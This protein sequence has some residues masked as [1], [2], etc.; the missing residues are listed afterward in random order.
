MLVFIL[1]SSVDGCTQIAILFHHFCSSFFCFCYRATLYVSAVFAVAR[2]PSVRQSICPIVTL[3]HCIHTAE[4]VVKLLSRPSS[5]II[6]VFDPQRWC[7]IPR[8]PLQWD[9]RIQGGGKIVAIFDWNRRYLGNGTRYTLGC[10]GTLIGSH[11]CRID[12]CRFRWPWVT[13]N[14]GLKV[15]DT[16][17]SNS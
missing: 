15:T 3:V 9:R 4:D 11:R 2:C 16:Y 5:L 14:Q 10:Y 6:L 17:K 13:P 12:L 7:P 8:E 1:L